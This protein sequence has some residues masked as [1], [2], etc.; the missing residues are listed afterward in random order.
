MQLQPQRT[1]IHRKQ[2]VAFP[3]KWLCDN[4]LIS[5][6]VLHHGRGHDKASTNLLLQQTQVKS[7][8]EY[9][10]HVNGINDPVIFNS[11]FD[12]IVSNFVLNVLPKK[13]RH[14]ELKRISYIT[15]SSAIFAVRGQ[16]CNGYV[17]ALQNWK[18]HSD[19][20]TNGKQF[21]KYYT[22]DELYDELS[23][24]FPFV[25]ILK[26]SDKSA[27]IIGRGIIL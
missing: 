3:T 23:L 21:Q 12:T 11:K 25:D 14:S 18:H 5:G 7:V 4:A 19:G 24:Y 13:E 27:L 26:G 15:A 10:P 17:T 8:M 22:A 6:Y 1:A 9:D 2:R 20:L 16:G